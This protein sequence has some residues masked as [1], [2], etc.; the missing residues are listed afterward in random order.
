MPIGEESDLAFDLGTF[1]LEMEFYEDAFE[2]L[3][4]SVE[5]YGMAPGA[6]YNIAVCYYNLNQM[7]EALDYVDHALSLDPDFAEAK[8]LRADLESSLANRTR[9]CRRRA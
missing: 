7:D 8:T 4:R 9:K 2:F 5:L 1:L 3:Q 6:A